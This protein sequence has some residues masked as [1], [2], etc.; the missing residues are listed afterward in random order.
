MLFDRR[1]GRFGTPSRARWRRTGT[2]F[3]AIKGHIR[4]RSRCQ[5]GRLTRH[6]VTNQ[7]G[8]A[9]TANTYLGSNFIDGWAAGALAGLSGPLA[10]S[11]AQTVKDAG[12]TNIPNATV[13]SGIG[14][15][16]HTSCITTGG[17]TFATATCLQLSK[18]AFAN[19]TEEVWIYG[20]APASGTNFN[21]GNATTSEFAPWGG[22]ATNQLVMANTTIKG[23]VVVINMVPLHGH[24][25]QCTVV[26]PPCFETNGTAVGEFQS[27]IYRYSD[28]EGNYILPTGAGQA[29]NT[30]LVTITA[31]ISG[32]TLNTTNG[33]LPLGWWVVDSAT[34]TLGGTKNCWSC[35]L[36]VQ[37]NSAATPDG[38][39]GFNYTLTS[40]G[41]TL[42][43]K[44][45]YVREIAYDVMSGNKSMV[46]GSSCDA[47][48]STIKTEPS[49][50]GRY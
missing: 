39:G 27:S 30:F 36:S 17:A 26:A 3:P 4:T 11:P 13:L 28:V 9:L 29:F 16:D 42:G 34:G 20:G 15:G 1:G 2:Y 43:P 32:M 40:T 14:T 31:S 38:S 22:S 24:T 49:C 10:T 7:D 6:T 35:T 46:D 37:I 19:S 23:N 45:M 8:L 47:T 44:T 41:P 12:N 5:R 21:S 33:T 25:A 50:T 18:T 48:D